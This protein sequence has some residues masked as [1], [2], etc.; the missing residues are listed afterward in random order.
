M[1]ICSPAEKPPDTDEI[2]K[3]FVMGDLPVQITWT[4]GRPLPKVTIGRP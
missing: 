3:H 2:Q 4:T 1:D